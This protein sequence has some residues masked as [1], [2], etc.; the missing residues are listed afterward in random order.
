MPS[1]YNLQAYAF[2]K[3][4]QY[5]NLLVYPATMDNYLEFHILAQCLL[6]EKNATIDGI[7]KTYFDYLYGLY[8]KEDEDQNLL[9][10]DALLRMCLRQKDA[11]IVYAPDNKGKTFFTF[12]KTESD[13]KLGVNGDKYNAKDFDELRLLICEQN[14]IEIPDSKISPEVR[15]SM[16]EAL[17]YRMRQSGNIP[18]TL[19]DQ[20]ICVMISTC[21]SLEDICKLSIRKFGQLLRRADAKLHYQVYLTAAMSGFVEFKDKSVLKHWMSGEEI[22]R[23]KDTT[24]SV[25][26][27]KGKLAFDDKKNKN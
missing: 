27:M 23:W 17:Y 16:E 25:E 14:D 26:A 2:D 13:S 18:P 11:I 22:D 7:S 10:F 15:K 3:P 8:A 19:E 6:L 24:I 21:L 20:V 9:K 12:Y 1:W 5:K 4:V